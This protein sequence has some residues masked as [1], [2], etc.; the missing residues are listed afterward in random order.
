M[1]KKLLNEIERIHE[2]MGTKSIKVERVLKEQVAWLKSAALLGSKAFVNFSDTLLKMK[3]AG[4]LKEAD[5]DDIIKRFENLGATADDISDLRKMLDDYRLAAVT[6]DDAAFYEWARKQYA[7]ADEIPGLATLEKMAKLSAEDYKILDDYFV[8]LVSKASKV[9]GSIYDAVQTYVSTYMKAFKNFV[10]GRADDIIFSSREDMFREMET[11]LHADLKKKVKNGEYTDAEAA[12]IFDEMKTSFRNNPSLKEFMESADQ[13]GLIGEKTQKTKIDWN[14]EPKELENNLD[15]DI[16][17]NTKPKLNA[18]TGKKDISRE[19]MD[20]QGLGMRKESLDDGLQEKY[21][22]AQ[23]KKSTQGEK[24]LTPVE[25]ELIDSVDNWKKGSDIDVDN[26]KSKYDNQPPKDV[27][28]NSKNIKNKTGYKNEAEQELVDAVDDFEKNGTKYDWEKLNNDVAAS[29]VD[30]VANLGMSFQIIARRWYKK[31]GTPFSSFYENILYPANLWWAPTVD[32]WIDDFIGLFKKNAKSVF[33]KAE[34]R[35]TKA[36]QDGFAEYMSTLSAKKNADEAAKGTVSLG[37]IRRVQ[38]ELIK[39]R[40]ISAPKGASGRPKTRELLWQN[41]KD[42]IRRKLQSEKPEAVN[43]F[44]NFCKIIDDDPGGLL[45]SSTDE[46]FEKG[47]NPIKETGVERAQGGI[48]TNVNKKLDDA[49][50]NELSLESLENGIRNI[51]KSKRKPLMERLVSAYF[52]GSFSSPKKL[53]KYYIENGFTLKGSTTETAKRYFTAAGISTI[54]GTIFSGAYYFFKS[55]EDIKDEYRN[56]F[57]DSGDFILNGIILPAAMNALLGKDSAL[58]MKDTLNGKSPDWKPYIAGW[59]P[60]GADNT[61]FYVFEWIESDPFKKGE[62]TVEQKEQDLEIKKANAAVKQYVL[63]N[64]VATVNN[65]SGFNTIKEFVS[66]NYP[67]LLDYIE[68]IE[69]VPKDYIKRVKNWQTLGTTIKTAIPGNV[70][71]VADN[72]AA[73]KDNIVQTISIPPSVIIKNKQGKKYLLVRG[74]DYDKSLTKSEQNEFFDDERVKWVSPDF[75]SLY[76][77]DRTYNS[78]RDFKL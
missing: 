20:S 67:K 72:V 19:K 23:T 46:I 65:I 54:I 75:D 49:L 34:A 44:D 9:G 35:M 36:M 70:D 37:P 78:L 12:D 28:D 22:E 76:S 58:E 42:N 11:R 2:L 24:S 61:L 32:I 18:K 71:D 60:G 68:I 8:S 5:I 62:K 74:S 66:E 39:F 51:I 4:T 10:D 7:K 77:G 63:N 59:F 38:K 73:T 25:K 29:Y 56:Q 33:Q 52:G 6:G 57:G 69:E 64:S 16:F 40:D 14:S 30:E 50:K 43:D 27:Y 45:V 53:Q 15:T 17:I 3:L 21:H 1:D 31:F 41:Y 47:L 48:I 26:L 55:S 13:A